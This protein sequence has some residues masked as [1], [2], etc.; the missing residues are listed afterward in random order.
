[1]DDYI[2]LDRHVDDVVDALDGDR[3]VVSELVGDEPMAGIAAAVSE[4]GNHNLG[5]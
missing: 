5:W 4:H 1:M 2:A 3:R